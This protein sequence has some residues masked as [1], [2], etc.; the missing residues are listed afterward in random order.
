MDVLGKVAMPS[1]VQAAISSDRECGCN[2][3][4]A[5]DLPPGGILGRRSRRWIGSGRS[6]SGS[7]I[8]LC[9]DGHPNVAVP[10]HD[11]AYSPWLLTR[12]PPERNPSTNP[13]ALA[14]PLVSHG[15]SFVDHP[16]ELFVADKLIGP[17]FENLAI[18]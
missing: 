12:A 4:L 2:S 13:I 3:A 7:A 18:M 9:F 1:L 17:V 5:A 11:A 15:S 8:Q 6:G 10:V 16:L 14:L